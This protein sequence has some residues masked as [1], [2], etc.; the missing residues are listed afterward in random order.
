M[1]HH[2]KKPICFTLAL[3]GEIMS[4]ETLNFTLAVN[5]G[6]GGNPLVVVDANGAV[7]ADGATVP[8]AAETVGTANPG[9]KLFTVSGGVAP[10]TFAVSAGAVPPGMD[11]TSTVNPDGSETVSLE[12]TPTTAN[13]TATFS[14]TVSDAAGATLTA[15]RSI[16]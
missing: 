7:L 9:E 2:H 8:L 6:G 14:V 5:G 13:A 3:E 15:R 16:R 4:Q 12:G 11:L 10:Y 1:H